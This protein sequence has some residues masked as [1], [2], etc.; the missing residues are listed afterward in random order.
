LIKPSSSPVCCRRLRRPSTAGWT[1][2]RPHLD[3]VVWLYGQGYSLSAISKEVGIARDSVASLL[4]RWR[5]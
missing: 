3:K 2:T 1:S 5:A 4:R